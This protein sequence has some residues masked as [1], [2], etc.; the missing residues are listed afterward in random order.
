M[1]KG[2]NAVKNKEAFCCFLE[3]A[4]ALRKALV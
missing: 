4:E 3:I 2:I 1:N